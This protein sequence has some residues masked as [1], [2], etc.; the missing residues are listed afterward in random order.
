M[1]LVRRFPSRLFILV[2]LSIVAASIA[3][4]SVTI[5]LVGG[6][7]AVL[8]WYITEGPR[9]RTL[10]RWVSNVL[11]IGL[12]LHAFAD[13]LSFPEP[14]A[15]ISTMAHFGVWLILIKL[16]ERKTARD[17][18]HLLM[19]TM[20]LMLTGCLNSAMLL[21]GV[22][23]LAYV[24][25][26]MYVLALFQFYAQ[27]ERM[28][29]ERTRAMPSDARFI[30]S[31]K[32]IVGPRVGVHFRAVS[33]FATVLVLSLSFVVFLLYPREIGQGMLREMDPIRFERI[34]GYNDQID[35]NRGG[36][37]NQSKEL[38][39]TVRVRDAAGRPTSLG[40][41]FYLRGAVLERYQ[42]GGSWLRAERPGRRVR[43][44]DVG[45]R[46]LMT[47]NP[48][49]PSTFTGVTLDFEFARETDTIFS[50]YAPYAMS[51]ETLTTIS[52]VPDTLTARR[53]FGEPLR[54]YTLVSQIDPTPEQ[55]EAIMDGAIMRLP[56]EALYRNDAVRSFATAI[57]RDA[58]VRTTRPSALD[59][60]FVWHRDVAETFSRHLESG[61]Y[62]Y[63][64]DLARTSRVRARGVDPIERFLL[65][66]KRGHC[67][68]FA[69]ALAAL[70]Q[71]VGVQA[72]IVTGYV[73]V[74]ST[75][76]ASEYNVLESNA[77]AW[78]EV[79]TS[80]YG[81]ST[82]D[83]V[84]TASLYE[85]HEA[86]HTLADRLRWTFRQF[87]DDW[88]ENVVDY[89]RDTQAGLTDRLEGGLWARLSRSLIDV[90]GDM[91]RI[92]QAFAL[93]PTGY[94]WMGLIVFAG[95]LAFI[96]I[97]RLVRRV[98]TIRRRA[99]LEHLHGHEYRRIVRQV[100]FYIDMLAILNRARLPKPPWLPPQAYGES[101]TDDRPAVAHRIAEISQAFYR[102][103]Y[104]GETLDPSEMQSIH[105]SVDALAVELDVAR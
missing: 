97:V 89:D 58:G 50:L 100:G 81:W 87:E 86:D 12:S 66:T 1:N 27:H 65:R 15:L 47:F 42:R 17:Y 11:M 14:E 79:R 28:R 8:S 74:D 85:Y 24:L 93:G 60:R 29:D 83:A 96:V 53:E 91:A 6:T 77:H 55:L 88:N 51:A 103:R 10:P 46:Q 7:L 20:L 104:G 21:Y 36:R 59:D 64:L 38:A 31:V 57:L 70:C 2:M 22:L 25:Y 34:S 105:A 52:Y 62:G 80:T 33:T 73:V 56:Q 94:I 68:F 43:I 5:L 63:T 40:R 4:E 61:E 90:R 32:P 54:R 98:R 95:V 48:E 39:F 3:Q 9:G 45:P 35:L 16:Y 67:E 71:S 30:P 99:H 49:A 44:L 92:N 23:L 78:V 101:F 76:E 102:V 82:Y 72:R 84:P 19:L 69:S 75:A 18:A 37:I 13:V 26:G 41:W